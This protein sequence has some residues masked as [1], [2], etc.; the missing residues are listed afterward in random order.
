MLG[1]SLVVY[2]REAAGVIGPSAVPD[3]DGVLSADEVA[4]TAA[5]IAALQ[6][7]MRDD[8]LVSRAGTATRGTTWRRPWPSSIAGLITEAERAYELAVADAT[9]ATAAWHNY[10]LADGVEDAK[11]DTN[12]CAYVATGV[13]HHWLITDDRGFVEHAVAGGRSG[14][15]TGCSRLQT[16]R[17]E[18]VWAREVDD[19]TV[20]LR[21]PHRLVV[22]PPRAATA[23]APGRGWSTS[24]R[25]DWELARDDLGRVIRTRPDVFEPKERWAMDWYYPV[26]CDVLVGAQAERRLASAWSTFV[27]PGLGVRCVSD[28]PWVTAAE[29]AECA[30]AHAAAGRQGHG[31]AICSRGRAPTVTRTAPTGPASST[32][33]RA[34]PGRR[35]HRVHG[36]GG[37][38]GR[39]HDQRDLRGQRHLHRHRRR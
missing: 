6:L 29:T 16:E 13:W 31:D 30:I 21:A 23:R 2:A 35:A 27:M 28:E 1:K 7:P 32:P 19:P 10:Y 12:V 3:I 20:D 34:L 8:P 18:I 26:L 4:E 38:P 22:D 37:D 5:S 15:S 33:R 39:R 25:P 24:T 36:R 9:T 17:G 11:L 14:P